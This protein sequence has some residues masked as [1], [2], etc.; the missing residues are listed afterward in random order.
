MKDFYIINLEDFD[1]PILASE[2]FGKDAMRLYN[3]CQIVMR[4]SFRKYEGCYFSPYRPGMRTLRATADRTGKT[5]I[6]VNKEW[7]MRNPL[8]VEKENKSRKEWD[9]NVARQFRVI[10]GIAKRH[11]VFLRWEG[12][13]SVCEPDRWTIIIK[14]KEVARICM[15]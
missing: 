13:G 2:F 6:E 8:E 5:L 9:E 14:N 3:A 7:E 10:Y 12:R 4:A 1:K 15:I 11:H